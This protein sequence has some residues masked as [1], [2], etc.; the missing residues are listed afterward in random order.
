MAKKQTHKYLVPVEI[1]ERQRFGWLDVK[2]YEYKLYA[3]SSESKCTKI[4][5]IDINGFIIGEHMPTKLQTVYDKAA[6]QVKNTTV[7]A[8]SEIKNVVGDVADIAVN[9]A[10]E[11]KDDVSK[12]AKQTAG[13]AFGIFGKIREIAKDKLSKTEETTKE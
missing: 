2:T 8:V 1:T 7:K 3:D 11:M 5:F 9:V 12:T 10:S 4:K 13:I 6:M